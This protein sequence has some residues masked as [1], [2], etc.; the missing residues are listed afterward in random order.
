MLLVA[1]F[2]AA[3]VLSN[4]VM[5]TKFFLYDQER[6]MARQSNYM[7]GEQIFVEFSKMTSR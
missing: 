4:N 1:T 2:P 3:Y 6:L 7:A 5:H